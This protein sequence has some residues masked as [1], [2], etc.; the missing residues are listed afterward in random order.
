MC[1]RC[2][3][4]WETG[5]GTHT[6]YLWVGFGLMFWGLQHDKAE[7]R[8][9]TTLL[10][11][12]PSQRCRLGTGFAGARLGRAIGEQGHRGTEPPRHLGCVCGADLVGSGAVCFGLLHA[13]PQAD[14]HGIRFWG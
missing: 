11:H 12:P 3:A 13:R 10:S 5:P 9:P 14:G 7:Q 6:E 8:T 1:Q 2:P 4:A